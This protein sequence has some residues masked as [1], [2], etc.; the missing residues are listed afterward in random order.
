MFR[1][2]GGLSTGEHPQL[3]PAYTTLYADTATRDRTLSLRGDA[4]EY[5]I[6]ENAF[7]IGRAYVRINE[8]PGVGISI[9]SMGGDVRW[10][11]PAAGTDVSCGFFLYSDGRFGFYSYHNLLPSDDPTILMPVDEWVMLEA[12]CTWSTS[13]PR[14]AFLRVTLPGEEPR[15]IFRRCKLPPYGLDPDDYRVRLHPQLSAG[16]LTA[17]P[18]PAFHIDVDDMGLNT[19]EGEVNNTWLGPGI[20][21]AARP[22]GGPESGGGGGFVGS[23]P[24]YEEA[25]NAFS[26]VRYWR[27]EEY[28]DQISPDETGNADGAY[29]NL[30]PPFDPDEVYA[31]PSAGE[32][33]YV[34]ARGGMKAGN[35]STRVRAAKSQEITGP[36]PSFAG[37][38]FTLSFWFAWESGDFPVRDDSAGDTGIIPLIGDGATLQYRFGDS[39]FPTSVTTASVRDGVLSNPS[40][41]AH[42]AVLTRH[43]STAT[44]YI[45]G[46]QVAS[47]TVDP[48][49]AVASPWHFGRNG[50]LGDYSDAAFDEIAVY[51][52]ALSAAEV[53]AQWGFATG[54][55]SGGSDGS[56]DGS[57]A[58]TDVADPCFDVG[59]P[60]STSRANF[61]ITTPDHPKG[62]FVGGPPEI[63][64]SAS[65][66]GALSNNPVRGMSSSPP[67]P[68]DRFRF[69]DMMVTSVGT[70]FHAH[71]VGGTTFYYDP[72]RWYYE[73]DTPRIAYAGDKLTVTCDASVREGTICFAR[74]VAFMCKTGWFGGPSMTIQ[75]PYRGDYYLSMWTGNEEPPEMPGNTGLTGYPEDLA[76]TNFGM[77]IDCIQEL[78]F[79]WR[80][81]LGRFQQLPE[82]PETP[83]LTFRREHFQHRPEGG[84]STPEEFAALQEWLCI[85][86]GIIYESGY[87][88]QEPLPTCEPGLLEIGDMQNHIRRTKGGRIGLHK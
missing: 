82:L 60:D 52:H 2:Y 19:S 51:D 54:T 7:L 83:T 78:E 53:L 28:S 43:G 58:F 57:G 55:D 74:A 4:D 1:H 48:D 9:F 18:S 6:P 46:V 22:I 81:V 27:V 11:A 3:I 14:K 62:P 47:D 34:I 25:V 13:G 41:R 15:I 16:C 63:T 72:E 45:D 67:Q 70:D 5:E 42:H 8:L 44:L 85:G 50:S 84:P 33:Y 79:S 36:T 71:G 65:F 31:T 37:S 73:Y 24:V 40:N 88:P 21:R 38:D 29:I 20:V 76:I 59:D 75:L 87:E 30:G 32:G 39:V 23:Y 86:A 69:T 26:P 49:L 35:Y 61:R 80:A 17:P 12:A 68:F 77:W 56:S 66:S 64:P 10:S